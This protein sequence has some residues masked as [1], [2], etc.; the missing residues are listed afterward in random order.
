MIADGFRPG[1]NHDIEGS[2]RQDRDLSITPQ[3]SDHHRSPQQTQDGPSRSSTRKSRS[4]AN[5]FAS[6]EDA[7]T[8]PSLRRTRSGNFAPFTHH[9]I[10]SASSAQY[11]RGSS[12]RFGAGGP[13]HPYAMYP[14]GT[15]ARTPSAATAST[16]RPQWQSTSQE[17]PRHPYALYPQGV[18]DDL[19]NEHEE[20]Q[21]PV[22]VGFLGLGHSFQRRRGPDGEEQDIVGFFGHTEQLP[23]Y[24]RYPEDGP[25]KAPLLGVPEPPTALHSRAPVLGT[26]PSMPLMH[27]HLQA[28]P[29]S[30]TDETELQRQLS[31]VSRTSAS[32]R[33]GDLSQQESGASEKSWKEKSW[34]ERRK[35]RF[36]GIPFWIF[37]LFAG[38]LA[39][40]GVILGAVLGGFVEGQRKA[41]G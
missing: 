5:P 41:K 30:M 16:A 17:G 2:G 40:F 1:Y 7:D 12:H 34:R 24:T 37:C 31:R 8:E 35:T 36:C 29:Q 18:T 32:L 21:N 11:A 26:D 4:Q 9:S 27:A 15:V 25:E 14:Q 13:T 33:S 22:P 39:F 28:T 10:S 38:T 23:P 3:P 19:D 20:A 6:P